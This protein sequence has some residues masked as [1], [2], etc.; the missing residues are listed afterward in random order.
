MVASVLEVISTECA[1]HAVK[2]N[3]YVVT[4]VRLRRKQATSDTHMKRSPAAEADSAPK[5]TP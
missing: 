3:T 4:P 2:R 5:M 1:L